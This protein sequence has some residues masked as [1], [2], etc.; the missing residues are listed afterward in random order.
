MNEFLSSGGSINHSA[1]FRVL[2]LGCLDILVTLPI[3]IL[4]LA[5][6]I[7]ENEI[8]FYQGWS[9]I[10]TDWEPFGVTK[11]MWA[12]TPFGTFDVK[13]N[14]W[15]SVYFALVFFALFGLTAEARAKYMRALYFVLQPLGIKPATKEPELSTVMFGSQNAGNGAVSLSFG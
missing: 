9:A 2:A 12:T 8:V 3:G 15:V 4:N 13:W 6:D 14:D 10:H 5:V 7:K 11:R 1:Y